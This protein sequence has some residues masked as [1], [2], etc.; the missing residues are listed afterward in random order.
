MSYDSPDVYPREIDLSQV[1]V[2]I[3]PGTGAMVGAS[4]RGPVRTRTFITDLKSL[5]DTFGEPDPTVSFMH[6]SAIAFLTEA[7]AL[8]V[9]R[10]VGSGAY[11]GT[12]VSTNSNP[13]YAVAG[14]PLAPLSP[15]EAASYS[16][17]VSDCFLIYAI[18]PGVYANAELSVKVDNVVTTTTPHTFD[19]TVYRTSKGV[20]TV[21]ETFTVSKS[22]GLDGFGSS[23]FIEDRVNLTSKYIR[24]LNNPAV[25]GDP[26][27]MTSDQFLTQGADGSTPSA[28]NIEG[29]YGWQL[30]ANKDDVSVNILMA[31]GYSVA[32]TALV[33]DT[34]AQSRRDCIAILNM[35]P[36]NQDGSA[37]LTYR[38]TT[39]N[40]NSDRS[41]IF[42][43]DVYIH[44]PYSNNSLFVPPDGYVGSVFSRTIRLRQPWYP[45]AGPN[46]GVL[47]VLGTRLNYTEGQRGL[48]YKSQVNFIRTISGQGTIVW[49][50]KTLKSGM[51]S[52]LSWIN[53]RMLLIVIENTIKNALN[54][55]LFEL[56]ND[57]TR[58]KVSSQIDSYMRTVKA[59]NGV[60]N[61]KV[62]CDKS[63]NT[64]QIIDQNELH[65]DV[66]VQPQRDIEYIQLQ[67]V[68]TRT[69]V[70]FNELIVTGGNFG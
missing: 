10:V 38:N 58:L 20:K 22:K 8:W 39:L 66:Y 34:I 55:A 63:N 35:P 56:N 9:T 3:S 6:Y 54:S 33:M 26:Y 29:T 37:E 51:M 32:S 61:Y 25:S 12:I 64:D 30:Y 70:N 14:A 47:N 19:I 50:N 41:A 13:G 31:G 40:L 52:A 60:Y 1:A 68:I 23:L 69:G 46:R 43:P 59:Q 28:G 27:V 17:G 4:S 42:S 15:K 53:V 18:G 21:V 67:S 16:F 65:V 11:H 62:V 7:K 57:F 49:G 24:V 36:G 5:I 48:L 2:G 45:A 44:D